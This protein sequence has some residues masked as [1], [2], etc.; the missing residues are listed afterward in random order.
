MFRFFRSGDNVGFLIE[1]APD[2]TAMFWTTTG[3]LDP[4]I[5]EFPLKHKLLRMS[6]R[7]SFQGRRKGHNT[8]FM[9][10]EMGPIASTAWPIG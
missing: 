1:M 4:D 7:S 10:C 3:L 2:R 9:R 6:F 5:V 8:P